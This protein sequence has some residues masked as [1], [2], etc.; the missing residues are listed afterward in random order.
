MVDKKLA[1]ILAI[2]LFALFYSVSL[3]PTAAMA[4]N[5]IANS[6]TTKAAIPEARGGLGELLLTVK[7]M[8]LVGRQP[9]LMKNMIR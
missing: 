5:P 4:V 1:V 8:R 9:H 6:W 3:L 2:A 7:Y